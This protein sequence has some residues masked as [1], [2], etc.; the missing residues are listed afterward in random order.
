[1][2]KSLVLSAAIFLCLASS[3]LGGAAFAQ[4]L[5]LSIAPKALIPV[6][7]DRISSANDDQLYLMSE[8]LDTTLKYSLSDALALRLTGG[9]LK[10]ELN[11]ASLYCDWFPLL[12]GAEYRLDLGKRYYAFAEG[13]LG[14]Y[15]MR[16]G[17]LQGWGLSGDLGL[18][19]GR[20]LGE[21]WDLILESSYSYS[22]V[23]VEAVRM[24]SGIQIKA[25]IELEL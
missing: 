24:L 23:G 1:M 5:S 17:R 11:A 13:E 3:A 19:V 21:D 2:K 22:L 9:Y 8:G 4:A 20:A 15:F 12:V 10:L 25:G 14:T 18:G 7:N 6:G 16:Y